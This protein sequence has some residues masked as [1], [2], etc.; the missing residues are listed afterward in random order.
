MTRSVRARIG[1]VVV[2]PLLAALAA[3]CG[4]EPMNSGPSDAGPQASEPA[5]AADPGAGAPALRPVIGQKTQNILNYQE[6][7]KN[8]PGEG[9]VSDLKIK[10]KDPITISGNAYVTAVGKISV[11]QIKHAVDL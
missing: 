6:E 4:D 2:G 10:A 7:V 5:P 9:Q 11:D 1:A 3:G 8:N